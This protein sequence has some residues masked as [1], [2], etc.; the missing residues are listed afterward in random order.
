MKLLLYKIVL[1]ILSACIV[2]GLRD[3]V[4]AGVI[5]ISLKTTLSI[6]NGLIQTKIVA[7]NTGTDAAHRLQG[8]LHIFDRT[9]I[10]DKIEQLGV[11]KSHTFDIKIRSSV[12][13]DITNNFP[14]YIYSG[15]AQRVKLPTC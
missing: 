9:I 14:Q 13:P 8:V 5:R 4:S 12:T 7:T 15:T 3:N 10:S 1:L 6:R 2:V 11:Q